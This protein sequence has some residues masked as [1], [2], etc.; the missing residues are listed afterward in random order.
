MTGRTTRHRDIHRLYWKSSRVTGTHNLTNDWPVPGFSTD[1]TRL[2]RSLTRLTRLVST[3]YWLAK[4]LSSEWGL[5]CPQL[6]WT[7]IWTAS[8]NVVKLPPR[9]QWPERRWTTAIGLQRHGT[10]S[11][12]TSPDKSRS[13][14]GRRCSLPLVSIWTNLYFIVFS[15]FQI[16][17]PLKQCSRT[18]YSVLKP[19]LRTVQ[20]VLHR[21][22]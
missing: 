2:Y 7:F 15:A 8:C 21:V 19:D 13:R 11:T 9:R 18:L 20:Y 17:A 3:A 1:S 5:V 10:I 12:S 14:R 6:L 4:T 16:D 22:A